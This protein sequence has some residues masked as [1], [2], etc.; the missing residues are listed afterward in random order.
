M[1]VHKK[2]LNKGNLTKLASRVSRFTST[3]KYLEENKSYWFV[4]SR[5]ALNMSWCGHGSI[6]GETSYLFLYRIVFLFT[7][8]AIKRVQSKY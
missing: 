5:L 1:N 4:Y 7:N 2:L 6:G 3:N 8:V